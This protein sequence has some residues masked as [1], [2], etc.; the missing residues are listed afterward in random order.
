MKEELTIWVIYKHPKDYPDNF[1][2]RKFILDKPTP[3]ILIGSTLEEIRKLLPP[4][5]TRFDRYETD[6]PVIIEAWI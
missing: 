2:A 3:E 6:D 5:S 4:G 1:V